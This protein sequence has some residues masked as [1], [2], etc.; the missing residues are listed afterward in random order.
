MGSSVSAQLDFSFPLADGINFGVE[1]TT[2]WSEAARMTLV[3]EPSVALL[4]G[5][6]L[7]LFM[8]R[9]R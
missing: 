4:L 9:R 6:T 1:T 5:A 2:N 3:P 8:A 7:G